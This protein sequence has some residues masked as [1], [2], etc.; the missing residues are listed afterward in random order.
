MYV[1]NKHF[2]DEFDNG[3]KKIKMADLL[4]YFV[5]YLNNLTLWAQ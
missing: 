4:R 5:F 1:T 2:L 3:W